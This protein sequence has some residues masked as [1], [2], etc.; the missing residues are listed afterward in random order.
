MNRRLGGRMSDRILTIE[1]SRV[2]S[3]PPERLW[4]LLGGPQAWSLRPGLFA[5]DVDVPPATSVRV[6]LGHAPSTAPVCLAYE[7]VDEVPGQMISVSST[8]TVPL[9]GRQL[10][11]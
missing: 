3:V 8:G 1:R 4:P 10:V 2:I 7:V 9:P 5:F 6:V 11:T